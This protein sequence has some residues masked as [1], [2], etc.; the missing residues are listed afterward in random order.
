MPYENPK[1]RPPDELIYV[2]EGPKAFER[3]GNEFFRY[4]VELGDLKP[5]E[6]VLDVGCAVGRMAVPLTGYLSET[7]GYEGFDVVPKGV[8]WCEENITP[9]YP[10]FRFR[11]ADIFNGRY[12]PKGKYRPEEYTFPYEDESFDFVFL[13]SVFTHML[14]KEVKN[15]ASEISRVL[16]PGG[17]CLITYFLLNEESLGLI[18]KGASDWEFHHS[19]G[20]WC[21][22]VDPE[23]PERAVAY[24]E[25]FVH[26][27]Y[28]R[29]GLSATGP[30][31]YGSWCGREEFLG[32]QDIIV[33]SR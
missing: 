6:R 28:R 3:M 20:K 15:Y 19:R 31:A 30:V 32:Y 29:N 21:R 9:R 4:F 25:R 22:V 24:D 17:R 16:K 18:E 1:I 11:L 2:G 12:N 23:Q 10:N 33:A 5:H 26:R 13:T 14:P 8:R 7:G 27:L